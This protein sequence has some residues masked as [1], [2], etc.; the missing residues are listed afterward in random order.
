[1]NVWN[2]LLIY[3]VTL[4][5]LI[6]V[7]L[8]WLSV[9]MKEFYKT[10]LRPIANKLATMSQNVFSVLLTWML[11]SLG[12]I[13]FVMPLIPAGGKVEGLIY[14][15]IFGFVV[16]GIYNLTNYSVIKKWPV[17]LVIIDTFWGIIVCAITG[18]FLA[19]AMGWFL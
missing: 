19:F 9:I 15:G 17:H 13:I 8:I 18:L 5:F 16:Y 3:I 11:V 7:D 6:V 14:G 4:V 2:Y 1:M 12:L 10:Q